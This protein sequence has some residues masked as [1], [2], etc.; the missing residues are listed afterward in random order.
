LLLNVSKNETNSLKLECKSVE[1]DNIFFNDTIPFIDSNHYKATDSIYVYSDTILRQ[2][3]L[4]VGNSKIIF[5]DKLQ[6]TILEYYNKIIEMRNIKNQI[7]NQ[8]GFTICPRINASMSKLN[9]DDKIKQDLFLEVKNRFIEFYSFNIRLMSYK[10][11]SKTAI[12]LFSGC[13]GDTLGLEMANVNV[14]GFIE[15]NED[16]IKSHELNFPN[17]KLIGKDIYNVSEKDLNTFVGNIDII[18]GGF[19]CQSFSRSGKKNPSDERGK[20]YLEFIRI[21]SIVKPKFIIGENVEGF[22][23]WNK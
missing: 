7:I 13:G 8:Y 1:N 22:N 10:N 2:N 5:D 14:V 11:T 12:S 9:I 18:F 15:L 20:L 6:N 16:A 21:A 4:F 23:C 19:P 17:S 3:I